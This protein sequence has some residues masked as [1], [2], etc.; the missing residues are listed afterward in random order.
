[1]VKKYWVSGSMHM[2]SK[3]KEN[4]MLYAYEYKD[5]CYILYKIR[6]F[7]RSKTAFGKVRELKVSDSQIFSKW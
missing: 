6:S 2:Q 4:S 1:M 7:W 3:R 5:V